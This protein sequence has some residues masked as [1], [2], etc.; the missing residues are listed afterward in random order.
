M[1]V[2][3]RMCFSSAVF[4]SSVWEITLSRR[5]K[6]IIIRQG[7][8]I[9]RTIFTTCSTHSPRPH[10]QPVYHHS[11]LPLPHTSAPHTL[12]SP[13]YPPHRPP[14]PPKHPTPRPRRAPASQTRRISPGTRNTSSRPRCRRSCPPARPARRR[15]T[16]RLRARGSTGPRRRI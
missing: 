2:V 6:R 16:R 10:Q 12:K 9:K 7:A 11:P 15:P 13:P 14:N 1:D 3:I 5:S 4:F 8:F